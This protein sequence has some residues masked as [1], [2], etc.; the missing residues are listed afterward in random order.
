[1][2][3]N[4]EQMIFSLIRKILL[5]FS[6][7]VIVFI[8]L[9]LVAGTDFSDKH[10][11][12]IIGVILIQT[13]MFFLNRL[14][15]QYFLKKLIT[16]LVLFIFI[17]L[18]IFNLLGQSVLYGWAL[19]FMPVMISILF[20]D[21]ILYYGTNIVGFVLFFA[22]IIVK[23]DIFPTDR[24]VLIVLYFMIALSAWIIRNTNKKVLIHLEDQIELVS[25]EKENN[26]RVSNLI[27]DGAETI[28][29]ELSLLSE[30]ASTFNESS[31]ELKIAVEDIAR[32]ASDQE[33]NM[34]ATHDNLN[35]LGSVIENIKATLL[36]F[37][38]DFEVTNNANNTNIELMNQLDHAN[39]DNIVK[40]DAVVKAISTLESA[41]NNIISITATIHGFAEQTN[42]LALNASIESARAG[43]AGRGFAVVAEEIR[44]LAEDTSTSARNIEDTIEDVKN[45]IDDTVKL[46]D[47]VN[48]QTQTLGQL[49]NQVLD[50]SHTLNDVILKNVEEVKILADQVH[51]VNETKDHTIESINYLSSITKEFAANSEEASASLIDQLEKTEVISNSIESIRKE[52]EKLISD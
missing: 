3:F 38:K 6:G 45:Q 23:D 40:N 42:L 27:K 21:G 31:S 4:R 13:G 11:I 10:L 41:V 8:G 34:R 20:I 33:N 9:D 12:A 50:A 28:Y 43:E 37:Q 32:G 39:K 25:V 46:V 1:M 15:D 17:G 47:D 44:K 18:A 5:I 51:H 24:E 16:T 14:K 35:E 52:N 49:S 19:L 30:Q 48:Q 26:Q 29:N 2:E 7:L 22:L 36:D